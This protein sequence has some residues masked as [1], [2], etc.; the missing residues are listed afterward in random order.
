MCAPIMQVGVEGCADYSKPFIMPAGST[1]KDI[2]GRAN[3]VAV[4]YVPDPVGQLFPAQVA[5]YAVHIGRTL[6]VKLPLRPGAPTHPPSDW[7]IGT[8]SSSPGTQLI[9]GTSSARES[10]DDYAA[11]ITHPVGPR[12]SAFDPTFTHPVRAEGGGGLRRT[13]RRRVTMS[14]FSLAA[15]L[16]AGSSSRTMTPAPTGLKHGERT[17]ARQGSPWSDASSED[18]GSCHVLGAISPPSDGARSPPTLEAHSSPL[19]AQRSGQGGGADRAA[20]ALQAAEDAFMAADLK[21]NTAREA[22]DWESLDLNEPVHVSD[23]KPQT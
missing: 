15:H 12:L 16:D 19:S 9:D 6:S 20:E 4:V 5:K 22:Q 17:V 21:Y 13:A 3:V 11:T 10:D 2:G 7:E 14:T 8:S 18:S 1:F 23:H